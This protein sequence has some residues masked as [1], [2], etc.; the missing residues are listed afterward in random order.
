MEELAKALS[1]VKAVAVMDKAES[2]SAIGG[3]VFGDVRSACYELEK[4]PFIINYIYGLGGRDI[5]VED[6]L[7][8]YSELDKIVKSGQPGEIYRHIGVRGV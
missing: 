1:H 5:R 7:T 4:R 8:V 2:F 6:F 3:P